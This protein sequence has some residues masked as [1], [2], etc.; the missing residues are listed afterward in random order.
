MKQNS[1]TYT[2]FLPPHYKQQV[3]F[4]LFLSFACLSGWY[5]YVYQPLAYSIATTRQTITTLRTE[6]VRLQ[7]VAFEVKQFQ[8]E[9]KQTLSDFTARCKQ[10]AHEPAQ[11]LQNFIDCLNTAEQQEISIQPG[12]IQKAQW[13]SSQQVQC[14]ITAPFIHT[15]RFF[16]HAAQLNLAWEITQLNISPSAGALNLKLVAQ[17]YSSNPPDHA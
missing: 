10:V 15:L 11:A 4:K 12:P 1:S 8:A 5:M 9:N 14:H 3:L 2:F 17:L 16:E 13:Y 7:T 6:T